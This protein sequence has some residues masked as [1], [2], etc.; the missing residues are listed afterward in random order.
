MT[1]DTK[2]ILEKVR[3]LPEQTRKRFASHKSKAIA[4][5]KM[6]ESDAILYAWQRLGIIEIQQESNTTEK[7]PN[8]SQHVVMHP[9]RRSW[10]YDWIRS[11]A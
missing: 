8:S 3:S 6:S 4:R 2:E 1:N 11:G 7:Q 5:K 9:L 10:L